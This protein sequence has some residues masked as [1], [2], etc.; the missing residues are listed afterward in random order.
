M[1]HLTNAQKNICL[2]NDYVSYLEKL[3]TKNR[4]RFRKAGIKTEFSTYI[5][6]FGRPLWLTLI[7]PECNS[8]RSTIIRIRRRRI[9]QKSLWPNNEAVPREPLSLY[10]LASTRNLP[11]K[12]VFHKNREEFRGQYFLSSFF[13]C[14][15]ILSRRCPRF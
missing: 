13:V 2:Y 7:D 5:N 1:K 8:L 3:L 4:N 12:S 9:W 11:I 10:G 15:I 6:T 14:P